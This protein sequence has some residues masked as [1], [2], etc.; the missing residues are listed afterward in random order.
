MTGIDILPVLV[1]DILLGGLFLLGGVAKARDFAAFTGT[2]G[3]YM[4][5]PEALVTP[6]AAAIVAA[7][8]ALGGTA[9][10]GLAIGSQAAM[11]GIAVLLLVYAAAMGINLLRGRDHI[12]CGCLGFGTGRASLGWELVARNL[13]LAAIALLAA[14]LPVVPRPLGAIDWISGVGAIIAFALLYFGFGQ[15]S[16]VRLQGRTVLK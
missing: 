11:A 5:V 9:M 4:L 15:F 12:D 14:A 16:A 2:L 10:A 8:L 1:A 7:E 6:V 13:G 3:N